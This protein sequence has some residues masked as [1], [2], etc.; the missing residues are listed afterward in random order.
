VGSSPTTPTAL[1]I[2]IL[3]NMK[4][5]FILFFILLSANYAKSEVLSFN[6]LWLLKNKKVCVTEYVAIDNMTYNIGDT[7]EILEP[8]DNGYYRFIIH[9]S[10]Y[11]ENFPIMY[12]GKQIIIEECKKYGYELSWEEDDYLHFVN[13]N[14]REE[15][16]CFCVRIYE[17][18]EYVSM[19]LIIDLG[20]WNDAIDSDINDLEDIKYN[21]K[22]WLS[23]ENLKEVEKYFLESEVE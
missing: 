9:Y 13:N 20:S 7:L 16:S 8:A 2:L 12:F 21:I 6:D 3:I 19:A 17:E 5:L 11:P 10:Y 14:V 15:L 23:E 22:S 18:L 4:K 1:T